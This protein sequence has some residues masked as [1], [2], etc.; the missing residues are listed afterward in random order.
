MTDLSAIGAHA[1]I[2]T[3]MDGNVTPPPRPI[4]WRLLYKIVNGRHSRSAE[5]PSMILIM[6]KYADPLTADIGDKSVPITFNKTA[7]KNTHLPL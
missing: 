2:S 5:V 4:K 3:F 6:I 7:M 1:A